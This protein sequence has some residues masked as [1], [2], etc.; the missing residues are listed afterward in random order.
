MTYS[1]DFRRLALRILSQT[2]SFRKAAALCNV[3]SSTLHRWATLGIGVKARVA[4]TRRRLTSSVVDMIR[5]AVDELGPG[6]VTMRRLQMLLERKGCRLCVPSVSFAVKRLCG[7][8]RKRTTRRFGGR[9]NA[10]D[11]SRQTTIDTFEGNVRSHLGLP[12]AL[13][14]SVDECY[15]S[16]KVLPL[17]GYSAIGE[18]CVVTSPTTSWMKRSL[19]L[20]VGSDGSNHYCIHDGSI[21]KQRFFHFITRLPYPPGTVIIL[22][23]VAFHKDTTPFVAKGFRPLFSPPYSPDHNGP[24]EN[25]F[26][27]VKQCFRTQWPWSDGV[28]A[29]ITSSIDELHESKVV[30]MFRNLRA[31]CSRYVPSE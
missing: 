27:C 30:A 31:L 28:N 19:L 13:V 14:V 9:K 3:S 12:G 7:L 4:A 16:E 15:F 6:A 5:S 24:V 11:P 20:A 2:R 1:S 22:D 18:K 23:N 10:A 25:S 29:A 26:S 8:S 21:N 17:Y